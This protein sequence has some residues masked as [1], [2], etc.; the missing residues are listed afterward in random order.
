VYQDVKIKKVKISTAW[1]SEPVTKPE[2]GH[3]IIMLHNPASNHQ[4]P[5]S[6]PL[7]IDII[8]TPVYGFVILDKPGFHGGFAGFEVTIEYNRG[9][10]QIHR[11]GF[12]KICDA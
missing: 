5:V 4:H 9:C 6:Q 12:I 10:I 3:E 7:H 8:R 11:F 2:P 1:Q